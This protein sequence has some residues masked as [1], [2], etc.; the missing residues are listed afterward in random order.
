M[1]GSAMPMHSWF[2]T[3]LLLWLTTW[4]QL[5]HFSWNS[6]VSATAL[7]HDA[8]DL[9]DSPLSCVVRAN[10]NVATM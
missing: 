5:A 2:N 9:Y 7:N 10:A 3:L 8:K 6:H 1:S 4:P